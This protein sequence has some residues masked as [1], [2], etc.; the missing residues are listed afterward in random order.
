MAIDAPG[1]TR[2]F[3]SGSRPYQLQHIRQFQALPPAAD[4]PAQWRICRR[5]RVMSPL[6]ELPFYH[7]QFFQPLHWI[8]NEIQDV[9]SIGIYR[10]LSSQKQ[11]TLLIRYV[12][13]L[14]ILTSSSVSPSSAS[15][16]SVM[17]ATPIRLENWLQPHAARRSVA[18]Q[19][20]YFFSLYIAIYGALATIKEWYVMC[21]WTILKLHIESRKY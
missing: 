19:G 17:S 11:G 21:R 10:R 15:P 7:L 5:T 3:Q 12:T 13:T 2:R 6:F 8:S 9:G 20:G 16:S 1:S 4:L 14:R 18:Y